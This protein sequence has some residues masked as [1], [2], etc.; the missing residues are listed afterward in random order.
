MARSETGTCRSGSQAHG[1]GTNDDDDDDDEP[2]VVHQGE[3]IKAVMEQ[4]D[5][6]AGATGRLKIPPGAPQLMV[7]LLPR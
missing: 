5:G 4:G 1:D 6:K 3:Y 2:P 7:R